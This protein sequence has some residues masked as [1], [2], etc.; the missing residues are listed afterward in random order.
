MLLSS[1]EIQG[2]KSFADKTVLKFGKGITAVVG[3][4]GSGKSNISDAVR[5]VLGEQSTKSLRGQSM[6]DVIF[7]GTET[8]RPHGFCEVTLNI[9]NT[10]RSLNFDNDF[11]SITRRYYRSH[12]S[13]YAINNVSVRLK[14]IHELFMDT[15]LGRDGYSMIGQGKIDNIISS[16]SNERR[17]IFE[18]AAGISKYRYRKLEAERKL[19]AAQDN[20]LRLHDIVDELESR[21]GPLEEQSK[22]AEKFLKLAEQKKELEIGLWLHTLNNSKEA[23][24]SQES[25]IMVAEA[26]YKEIEQ[27]LEDF[28]RK[29]E[30]NTSLFAK[31]TSDIE[32]ERLN[33][34]SVNED[35]VKS[36]GVITVLNNDISH[37]E[38]S[39]TRLMD[40]KQALL[41]SDTDAL[42]EIEAKNNEAK[43]T[44]AKK[45]ELEEKLHSLE[46]KLNEL[47]FENDTNSRKIEN[48]IR[49]LNTLTAKASDMRVKLVTAETAIGEI[50]ARRGV[51][52][53][54]IAGREKEI[55]N[56]NGEFLEIEKLLDD[57]EEKI[58]S[59][60]NSLKGYQL[61]FDSRVQSVD[62]LKQELDT[63]NLDVEA[64]ER[65]IQILR[66]LQNNMDGFAHSVKFVISKAETGL[67][68]GI[69]GPISSL[70]TVDSKYSLAI[71]T[72]LN[73]AIQNIV[74]ET[75]AD[76]K[77]AINF[78]K[79][80]KAGRATFLPVQTIKSRE[81]KEHGFEDMLGYV[82]IASDLVKNDKKYDEIVKYLLGACVVAE[83][84]D[85][86]VTIAK[87]FGYRVKVVTLDGQV[88]SPGGS[89]TGG[90]V[91][92]NS[93]ILSRGNDIINIEAEVKSLKEKSADLSRRLSE[94]QGSLAEVEA[95]I[96]AIKADILTANED[97]IRAVSELKRIGDIRESVKLSLK[98]L[99]DEQAFGNKKLEELKLLSVEAAKEISLIDGEK[100]EIQAKIDEMSGNRESL[101]T[102]R[103]GLANSITEVKLSVIEA[104]KDIEALL[105]QA[106]SLEALISD[107]AQRSVTIDS[108]IAALQFKNEN[109]KAEIQSVNDSIG[110]AKAKIEQSEKNIAE[111]IEKR[112]QTEKFGVE[113]R[114]SER[115]NTLKREQIGGELARLTERK[116]VMM[117]E[118]DDVIRKLYDEYE[119]TRSEAEKIGIEI[120][121]P[122]QAKKELIDIKNKIRS[123]GNV[124]VSAI[125][126]FKEVSERY[127]F[128]SAQIDD[129]EAS[130]AQLQKLIN[131]LTSQMQEIFTEG[132]EK[133][134]QNFTKTFTELFGG[135]TASLTLSDPENILESGID[136]NVKLPGKNVPSLDGLSGGEKAL[137]ALSIYFAIMRV[138]APPFC[139]LDEVD[140]ALDDINVERFAD[141]MRSS[142]F[143]TQFICVTHRRGTMEAADMLYGVTMQ[144]KGITKLLELN[145]SELEKKLHLDSQGA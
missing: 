98:E 124:N 40:E 25:K 104:Q 1:I 61:R 78:L 24:R 16:K 34:S 42:A 55:E 48:E 20:L 143:N 101:N 8:R 37:N 99:N 91:I 13:E 44:E 73:N 114:N 108:E 9:N 106:T 35:I 68:R 6:E 49:A 26:Q 2:F 107:R 122:A 32:G 29:T 60:N 97:K 3:P 7:G 45:A 57:I 75:E 110:D 118:Y 140:T 58:E 14:D 28:D 21:V 10:D 15:G 89:L 22:K 53:D 11:V 18:E 74:T 77:A 80:N 46:A 119:L 51:S 126:E 41:N 23:L 102:V 63:V 33:I 112:N 59:Y 116:E 120:E 139:F 96:T 19:T 136:I 117:R 127:N 76:A 144:E 115:E 138:N 62:K 5:W 131:Q 132:F 43:E 52:V 94:A 84:I 72:A 30:Q 113:L 137:I 81:F 31:L 103:E 123:L 100:A 129:V 133:I 66:D 79:N 4:N 134:S 69:C 109:L 64:K 12:E 71:E 90:S 82:G 38:E 65:R 135:G 125:E 27:M 39:I 36:N 85:C 17:D 145:V 50:E 128:L 142:D 105:S 86:A 92:K 130:R 111:L 88:V 47:L 83:D 70:I 67:L 141:Y 93:G 87:K 54:L 95:D 121:N 56:L